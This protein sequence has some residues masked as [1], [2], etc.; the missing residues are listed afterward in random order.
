M[1]FRS[2]PNCEQHSLA[3]FITMIDLAAILFVILL[4]ILVIRLGEGPEQLGGQIMLFTVCFGILRAAITIGPINDFDVLGLLS[5]CVTFGGL[6]W[7]ALFAW[8]VWPLWT[9][10]LQLLA[11]G[12]H[13]GPALQ[14]PIEPLA[15]AIMRMAPTTIAIVAIVGATILHRSRARSGVSTPPWRT[16]SEP[17]N[18]ISPINWPTNFWHN[19]AR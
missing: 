4:L 12:A 9:A 15:Y 10:A 13:F 5:D 16:W 11:I 8:R 18:R 19:M 14:L 3:L 2:R 7:I 1:M 17:L 6:T